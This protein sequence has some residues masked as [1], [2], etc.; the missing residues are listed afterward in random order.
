[1]RRWRSGSESAT[2]EGAAYFSRTL[3][4]GVSANSSR[5]R[6]FR[7]SSCSAIRN[8]TSSQAAGRTSQSRRSSSACHFVSGS[9]VTTASFGSWTWQIVSTCRRAKVS[10]GMIRPSSRT[11]IDRHAPREGESPGAGGA[12]PAWAAAAA[13]MTTSA[14]AKSA[15]RPARGEIRSVVIVHLVVGGPGRSRERHADRVACPVAQRH[16]PPPVPP[17][18]AGPVRKRRRR[19]RPAAVGGRSR[20]SC[21]TS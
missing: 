5:P 7:N 18:P 16:G 1:M 12:A 2:S 4:L 21:K 9:P 19:P 8:G 11:G 6:S 10:S 15:R 13:P 17:V 20:P 3:P 14:A